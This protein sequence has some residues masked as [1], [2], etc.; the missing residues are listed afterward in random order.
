MIYL[1][2]DNAK[3]SAYIPKNGEYD[4]RKTFE[5]GIK[6]QQSLI[7]PIEIIENGIYTNPN[8]Y[9]PVNVNIPLGTLNITENGIYDAKNGFPV[10]GGESLGYTFFLK[11]GGY[12]FD[13]PQTEELKVELYYMSGNDSGEFFDNTIRGI[14]GY[15]LEDNS[16]FVAE[17]ANN[18]NLIFAHINEWESER[19]ELTQNEWHLIGLS[20]KEF[21]IDGK[22]IATIPDGV[23]KPFNTQYFFVNGIGNLNGNQNY[24]YP[25]LGYYNK[26]KINDVDYKPYYNNTTDDFYYLG[27]N[28][29]IND[30]NWRVTNNWINVYNFKD[31]GFINV[32]GFDYIDVDVDVNGDCP[33]LETLNVT[34]NGTYEG[35]FNVVN[36][37]V[38]THPNLMDL[39]INENG[40]YNPNSYGVDGFGNIDVNVTG[41]VKLGSFEISENGTYK[42]TLPIS[43]FNS[44]DLYNFT[45]I[46][47]EG[48]IEIKFKVTDT[49][50][51][52]GN[53]TCGIYARGG[54]WVDFYWY[55]YRNTRNIT[56]GEFNTIILQP[57]SNSYKMYINGVGSGMIEREWDTTPV[58]VNIGGGSFDF[59]YIKYWDNYTKYNNKEIPQ[60]YALPSED[61]TIK[62]S[63]NGGDFV[64]ATNIGGG[65]TEYQLLKEYDGWNEVV[66][67]VPPA[68]LQQKYVTPTPGNVNS[69]GYLNYAPD[70]GFEGM[71][72]ISLQMSTYNQMKYDEGYEQGYNEGKAEGGDCPE[73][74]ELNVTEN[75]VYEGAYNIVNVNVDVPT[76]GG[77]CDYQGNAL[78]YDTLA[79]EYK[80]ISWVDCEIDNNF[81][82]D[83]QGRQGDCMLMR[84]RSNGNFVMTKY[85]NTGGSIILS[86]GWSNKSIVSLKNYRIVRIHSNAIYGGA[87]ETIDTGFA[88]LHTNA[89]TECSFLRD[90]KVSIANN[91]LSTQ[92]EE[93]CFNGLP[94]EGTLIYKKNVDVTLSDE[95]IIAFFKT[96]V[97]EDWTIKYIEDIGIIDVA[98]YGIKF[99]Y[100]QFDK[101]P[102]VY[103]FRGITNMENLFYNCSNLK[104]IPKIDTS[105][106]TNMRAT[107]A[108][109]SALTEVPY[110]D[111]S[112]VTTFYQLFSNCTNLTTI[113]QFNSSKVTTMSSM[114]SNNSSLITIPPL[115]CSSLT[116]TE[117]MGGLVINKLTNVG[118]FL[119]LK[120]SCTR[121]GFDKTPNLTYE[122][123]INILNG[124]Y[125]FTGNG[126][127]PTSSQ[128]Q[129]KVHSNFLTTVGDEISIATNKGWQIL[130]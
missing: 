5:D 10:R 111:T 123:C 86:E 62:I 27:N 122:S 103:D 30:I 54:E 70:T 36:V 89:I 96:R 93:G 129:L 78:N 46:N 2:K 17:D 82:Q 81:I 113:P 43:V 92:F 118:G 65:I 76:E 97:P 57:Y 34:D 102:D 33:E 31:V 41:E 117:W 68:K 80:P 120:T 126:E 26:L 14:F 50:W 52:F 100:S 23:Y 18:P 35:A 1:K 121:N 15:W 67:N 3:Q 19:V 60:L 77:D 95:E 58:N 127:T 47:T 124:L 55:G 28:G 6:Y 13:I 116:Q 85:D 11:G 106:V 40:I 84:T 8:G 79:F 9:S 107:F 61:N 12:I 87:L 72:R 105:N 91:N 51:I 66:V 114:F 119:N 69:S 88:L 110:M 29:E 130:A 56:I 7:E 64:P 83:I 21:S 108:S 24:Y 101:V 75:G 39:T 22:I 32:K 38:N 63:Q 71:S 99:G 112:N 49:G 37:D 4:G 73:L 128:G 104:E 16:F 115:D 42:P 98:K 90:I 94:S 125:D 48:V 25:N 45:T 53:E 20:N 74:T 109:C 44:D 59:V